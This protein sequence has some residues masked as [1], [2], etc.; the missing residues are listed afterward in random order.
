MNVGDWK[1]LSEDDQ[2]AILQEA[3]YD[4]DCPVLCKCKDG[5]CG[6]EVEPD[7]HCEHGCPSILLAVGII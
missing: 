3:V 1:K 6:D 4:G 5:D 2:L 7:G